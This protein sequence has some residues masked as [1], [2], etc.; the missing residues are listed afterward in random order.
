LSFWEYNTITDIS[1]LWKPVT[2]PQGNSPLNNHSHSPHFQT[3]QLPDDFEIVPLALEPLS[4]KHEWLDYFG[5]VDSYKYCKHCNEKKT[6][7]EDDNA[8]KLN[9]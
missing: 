2:L 4:C 9:N 3:I 8:K 6:D 5:L 1:F 7:E